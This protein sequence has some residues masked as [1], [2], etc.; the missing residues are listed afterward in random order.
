MSWGF[1]W[2]L[3]F[4]NGFW[5]IIVDIIVWLVNGVIWAIEQGLYFIFDGLLT[6]VLAFVNALDF[7]SFI[8]S[9]T[10]LWAALP[11]GVAY[12]V[13]ACGFTQG[14]SLISGAIV[15]REVGWI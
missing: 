13:G 9:V 2:L 4:V 5:S 7:T 11:G 14:L 15:I 12:L 6:A 3:S 10:G 8:M 1:D